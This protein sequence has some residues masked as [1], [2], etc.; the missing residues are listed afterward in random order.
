MLISM[1]QKRGSE[2]DW[3]ECSQLIVGKDTKAI[4]G[5]KIVFST[6][7]AETIGYP[8]A[9]TMNFDIYLILHT[10]INSKLMINLS[11]KCETR[12]SLEEI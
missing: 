1:E 2:I 12:Q 4:N 11:I 7:N 3:Y 6:N 8:Y 10:K 5:E 9:E